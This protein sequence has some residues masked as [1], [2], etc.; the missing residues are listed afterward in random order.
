MAGDKGAGAGA[1]A[2][3]EMRALAFKAARAKYGPLSQR[4][5]EIA[6]LCGD[7]WGI[8]KGEATPA[9]VTP[10]LALQQWLNTHTANVKEDGKA[11]PEFRAAIL[12]TFRNTMAPAITAESIEGYAARLRG[13]PR[14]LRAVAK[15]EGGGAGWDNAGLL[16]CLW[17][18][19]YLW[20]RIRFAIPFLSDPKPGGYTIDADNDGIN[21]SWEKLA[22]AA[23]RFG[24]LAFECASFGKFQVMGG[25]WKALGY[26]SVLDMV[27]ELSR[28][29]KAH[30]EL[31]ARYI[32]T[33]GLKAA[34]RKIDGDPENAREFAKG[35]NGAGYAAGRYHEKIAA[36]WKVS[37]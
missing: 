37:A 15:V 23:M 31:L 7:I 4:E 36:A 13:T 17:E 12:A 27:W 10:V 11:S 32:E 9:R 25:H 26:P 1:A 34:L 22:D 8:P 24:A 28:S 3:S 16:K 30:Y 5:V 33:N 21:D 35:Y 2:V 20:K 6:D 29:E 18:R 19:H 14:Q